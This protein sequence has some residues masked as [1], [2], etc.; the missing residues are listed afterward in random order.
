MLQNDTDQCWL[1]KH[2]QDSHKV[3]IV[4]SQKE[5]ENYSTTLIAPC[6]FIKDSP[7]SVNMP[8]ILQV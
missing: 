7:A 6:F 1:E 5:H 4:A 8:G 3:D 2:D